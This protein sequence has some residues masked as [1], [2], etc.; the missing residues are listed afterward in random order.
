[1]DA[2]KTKY[3]KKKMSKLRLSLI[4]Q[5]LITN[6][7]SPKFDPGGEAVGRNIEVRQGGSVTEVLDNDDSGGQ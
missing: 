3:M 2:V 6:S 7:F 4:Y 1:M 5:P